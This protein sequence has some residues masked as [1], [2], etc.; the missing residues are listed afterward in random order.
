LDRILEELEAWSTRDTPATSNG[1]APV[2]GTL[3]LCLRLDSTARWAQV[4]LRVR[5][6][7]PAG[8][9]LTLSFN[10]DAYGCQVLANG[11]TSVLANSRATVFEGV[12]RSNSF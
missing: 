9:K 11:Y 12:E 4:D 7:N 8:E 3:L 2:R 10:G 6:R 1:D 5:L